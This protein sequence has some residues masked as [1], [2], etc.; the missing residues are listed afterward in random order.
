MKIHQSVELQETA[1]YIF[2]H[3]VY[4]IA[5]LSDD[6]CLTGVMEND[7]EVI[8]KSVVVMVEVAPVG[9]VNLV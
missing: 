9:T 3:S 1:Q 8:M 4:S 5:V 7:C 6:R 2:A